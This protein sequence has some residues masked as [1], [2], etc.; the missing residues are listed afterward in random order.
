MNKKLLVLVSVGKLTDI[1]KDIK[2]RG[3]EA[4]FL[5]QND[6]KELKEVVNNNMKDIPEECEVYHEQE[7]YEETLELCKRINPLHILY[8]SERSVELASRLTTDLKL[9][10]NNYSYVSNFL[11]KSSMHEAL[12]QFG[13]RYIKGEIAYNTKEA[14]EIFEKFGKKAVVLKPSRGAASSD[15]MF[16]QNEKQL[17]EHAENYFG[18]YNFLTNSKNTELLIQECITG[19]EY[20]IN[21]ITIKGKTKIV[22]I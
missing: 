12:K 14:K 2:R 5:I 6:P 11:E 3:F 18:S 19:E 22:G 21:T 16:C 4:V 15:L 20:A 8:I 9:L 10:G 17:T 13:I 1:V 7:T